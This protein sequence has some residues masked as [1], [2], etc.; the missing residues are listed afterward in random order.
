VEKS[1]L[2]PLVLEILR[3]DPQTHPSA[4]EHRLKSSVEGYERHDAL[5]LQEVIWELLVQG[6]LAPGKNSA[7]LHLPF[8]HVTEY[9]ARCLE[10]DALLLPD[11]DGYLQALASG[12]PSPPDATLFFYV[13][14]ALFCFLA[15]RDLAALLCLGMAGERLVDLLAAAAGA[16]QVGVGERAALRRAVKQAGRSSERRLEAARASLAT[17]PLPPALQDVLRIE[18]PHLAALVRWTRDEE[19]LPVER[20]VDRETAH[21]ALLTFPGTSER[22]FSL[23][24]HLI[25]PPPTSVT[26]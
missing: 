1:E 25:P 21:A 23:I 9:G 7:N 15:G 18:V 5:K 13:R 11:P 6:V 2:R 22:V 14:E 3:K 24:T 17:A 12:L 19:G 10:E 16:A 4:I 20:R 26:L 8:V